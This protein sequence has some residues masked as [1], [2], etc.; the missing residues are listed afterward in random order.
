MNS[1]KYLHTI[2]SKALISTR[3]HYAMLKAPFPSICTFNASTT[4]PSKA[5]S[6]RT[7]TIDLV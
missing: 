6:S 4:R 2:I 5:F 1:C 7:Y 3:L